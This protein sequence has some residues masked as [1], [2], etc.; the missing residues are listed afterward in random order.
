MGCRCSARE[1]TGA[2][3]MCVF[4]D[5]TKQL[6]DLLRAGSVRCE[7]QCQ[8]GTPRPRLNNTDT[9]NNPMLLPRTLHSPKSGTDQKNGGEL[10]KI[11]FSSELKIN[12]EIV[13]DQLCFKKR[14][15]ERM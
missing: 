3:T 11:S 9:K 8:T 5:G 7:E 14:K 1:L 4:G 15:E 12:I 10:K 13:S 6:L 2:V